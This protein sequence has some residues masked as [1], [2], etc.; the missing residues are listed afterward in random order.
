MSTKSGFVKDGKRLCMND[1]V[2]TLNKEKQQQNNTI[3]VC[4]AVPCVYFNSICV[5]LT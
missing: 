2:P 3:Y 4:I 5:H 1:N